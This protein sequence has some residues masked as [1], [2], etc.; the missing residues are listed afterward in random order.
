MLEKMSTNFGIAPL[1]ELT[2]G[3]EWIEDAPDNPWLLESR[4]FQVA[5][6]VISAHS[7]TIQ[8]DE[9]ENIGTV[10]VLRDITAEVEAEQ[11]KDAFVEHVSHEL[12]TPLTSIKGYSALLLT[13]AGENLSLQQR[14]FIETII[15]QT[16]SLT[17]MVNA[18]LDF[19]EMQASGRL[20]VRPQPFALPPLLEDLVEE[21]QPKIQDKGVIFEYEIPSEVPLINGD[22]R[23]LRWALMNLLRNAYQYTAEG[24][25]IKLQLTTQ[26]EYVNIDVI[27]TG[28]GISQD[29][30]RRIFSRF[31]RVMNVK[32]DETRGLGLG[33]Y[34][35]KAIVDAHQGQIQ[36]SSE[37]GKGST[38]SMQLPILTPTT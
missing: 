21:W 16:E 3:H 27:D 18:L 7:A 35:T 2:G 8:T 25:S 15:N 20:G 28:I 36:I 9:D 24:G 33:L 23:R 5:D 26:D 19:S 17:T 13:T 37:L 38:F 22:A 32:D 31:Y 1:R 4:R 29:N 12:R 10:V 30:Q 14:M 11:L 6:K 34:V